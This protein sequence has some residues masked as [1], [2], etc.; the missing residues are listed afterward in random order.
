MS[1]RI[2]THLYR[3]RHGFFYF[4]LLI[5]RDLRDSVKRR[6]IRFS[7]DTEQR[8]QALALVLPIV[9]D[10]PQLIADLRRMTDNDDTPGAAADY[11]KAWLD[12]KRQ[13]INLQARV[14]ELQ[15][16]LLD[17]ERRLNSSVPRDKAVSVVKTAHI[18]GQLSGKRELEERL[19]FPWLPERT[20]SF[21]VLRAAWLKSLV[22]NRA[23]GGA[24][25]PPTAK[26]LEEYESTTGFFISVMGDMRIGEIDREIVGAYFSKLQQLPPNISRKK[27]YR[28]KSIDEIID[29]G[30][31]PQT[32]RNASKKMEHISSMFKWALEEK[33]KWG[34]DANPFT[35]YG[36][37]GESETQR[38][39]FTAD[40]VRALFTHPDFVSR[41]FANSYAYWLIPLAI[42]TG[43]RL[44]ELCQLDLKDI[45]EVEGV[46]CIDINDADAVEVITDA[47]GRSKR[48]KNKNARR[49]V[50]IHS[51]LIEIG[52][53]RYVERLQQQGEVH[54]FPEL[55]R[56]RR[57][58]PGHAASNW[59][60]RFRQR[61]GLN[62]KQET[63]FHSFRHMFITNILDG[64][65]APHLLA[66][67]VGH[68]AELITGQVY[69]NKKDA[70][71]RQPTVEAFK[72]PDDI[73][74][75]FPS[76]EDVK[77]TPRGRRSDAG[78]GNVRKKRS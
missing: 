58:G 18:K 20:A 49:L 74:K 29:M 1:I 64:G 12:A 62:A 46:P 24:K 76:I 40:E 5:P 4:R 69:W 53:L 15:D 54:L 10:L 51:A 8:Q 6:E 30:D 47:G 36:Q 19:A 13:N 23:K 72:L 32:G 59:F 28:G 9:A 66:P 61:I 56:T 68:E 37:A 34:I 35:G 60:Q 63:V 57:D 16:K 43:A 25:K 26:T 21:S 55:N 71:K 41:R 27:A 42:F 38:R 48:V 78:R 22:A 31:P 70:T 67:I 45:T 73:M 50:P 33:R 2:A 17:A 3:N 39:P 7:L 77:F 14:E 52:L 44:T 11:F 65:T 75:L